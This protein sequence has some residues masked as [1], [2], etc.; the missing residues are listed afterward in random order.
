MGNGTIGGN[1]SDFLVVS[2][3]GGRVRVSL[4][5]QDGMPFATENIE[6]QETYNDSQVHRLQVNRSSNFLELTVDDETVIGGSK[7][8]LL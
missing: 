4:N 2:L 3:V 7:L 6:T 5:F 8:E 1:S